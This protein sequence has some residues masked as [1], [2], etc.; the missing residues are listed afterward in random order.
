MEEDASRPPTLGELIRRQREI[1]ELPMRRLASLVGISN[2]YLSQ[3]ERNLR[4]PSDRVLQAIAD[5]LH[6]SADTLVAESSRARTESVSALAKAI[7]EDPDLTNAQRR[8]LEEMYEAFREITITKRRR[9]IKDDDVDD[10]IG[11]AEEET[12][13]GEAT[14]GE[15][16]DEIDPRHGG[17]HHRS[18]E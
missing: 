12:P 4:A 10:T 14:D 16:T 5:Q 6:L 13:D 9:G 1:A 2:P 11:D 18:E 7:R 17:R 8:T 15:A 3:I